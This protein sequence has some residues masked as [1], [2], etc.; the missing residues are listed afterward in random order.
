MNR[1]L[2]M[3]PWYAPGSGTLYK[4]LYTR[5]HP[6]RG[7]NFQSPGLF[8][9]A[10]FGTDAFLFSMALL[11]EITGLTAFYA[12]FDSIL[13]AALFFVLDFI[14]AIGSHWNRGRQAELNNQL[15]LVHDFVFGEANDLDGHGQLKPI[16][17]RIQWRRRTIARFKTY[18]VIFY[19]LIC[20]I[21][22]FKVAG[23]VNGWI[24]SGNDFGTIPILI[25]VTY[26]LV[27]F[28]HIYATGYFFAELNVRRLAR[29]EA[30][31]H[32]LTRHFSTDMFNPYADINIP[33]SN[34]QEFTCP[35]P[36]VNGPPVMPRMHIHCNNHWLQYNTLS[37]FGVLTDGDIRQI[38]AN[39]T[40]ANGAVLTAKRDAF[41]KYALYHQLTSILANVPVYNA[42][43]PPNSPDPPA[44]PVFPLPYVHPLE[45]DDD[46]YPWFSPS[47]ETKR[48]WLFTRKEPY[49]A[50]TFQAPGFFGTANFQADTFLFSFALLLEIVGLM[51]FYLF[52]GNILFAALFFLLDFIFAIGSHWNKGRWTMLKNQL[53]VLSPACAPFFEFGEPRDY[54]AHNNVIPC[55]A[56]ISWRRKTIMGFK[57]FAGIFY[58]LICAIAAFKAYGFI[59]GWTQSGEPFGVIPL[60][61]ATTYALVAFIHVYAT[62][63]FFAEVYYRYCCKKER[64]EHM[65]TH[66]Y[67]IP[68]PPFYLPAEIMLPDGL[69]INGTISH[70]GHY[71]ADNTLY[72]FGLIEDNHIRNF[73][74]ALPGTPLLREYFLKYA[75]HHQIVNVMS[76]SPVDG[77]PTC[78]GA[79]PGPK[80]L[81]Q[82]EQIV[83]TK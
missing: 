5:K 47:L 76:L 45:N 70:Q 19:L 51:A 53:S 80:P 4:W 56:R 7:T 73:C 78:F 9:T 62:G 29:A 58:F 41:L 68:G 57:V 54:D 1:I 2:Q 13:F 49:Q 39:I 66:R 17:A 50:G 32:D 42:T 10:G 67:T 37:T 60:L 46:S 75:L 82:R 15:A 59:E 25:A 28:I 38:R 52:F 72:T 69:A 30:R 81:Q 31:N 23:F 33:L 26:A 11:L 77:P 21:A 65:L 12:F 16:A 20:G 35:D 61:I 44:V 8:E 55:P 34:G 22:A 14:F 64:R 3:F 27:A 6:V 40:D 63:Y 83:L 36:P 48:K 18:S 43:P 24:E 79:V 74:L 71:L